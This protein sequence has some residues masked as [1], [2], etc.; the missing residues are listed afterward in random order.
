MKRNQI[1]DY[2]SLT[3]NLRNIEEAYKTLHIETDISE[4][5]DST[6][7]TG[8]SDSK[9]YTISTDVQRLTKQLIYYFYIVFKN[10]NFKELTD[11]DFIEAFKFL[12][13]DETEF[14][15]FL[16]MIEISLDDFLHLGVYIS[17]TSFTST[18]IKFIQ[19]TYL[20][21]NIPPKKKIKK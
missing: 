7:Y 19:S 8:K 1:I 20:N 16:E 11:K 5:F 15:T 21:I 2:Q 9:F 6:C 4:Y 3:K 10:F 17:P 12:I 18:L 13:K 14:R